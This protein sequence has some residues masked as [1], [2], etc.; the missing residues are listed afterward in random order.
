V[1][2]LDELSKKEKKNWVW[3]GTSFIYP[4]EDL[5]LL[6]L[7]DG[8]KDADE[9]REFDV[10]TKDFVKGGFF[11]PE[12]KNSVAWRNRDE[13]WVAADFGPG[14]MTKSG[15]PR[16][17][18]A[19]KRGTPLSAAKTIYEGEEGDV[20][21][22]AYTV[23]DH[24]KQYEYIYRGTSFFTNESRL[25]VGGNFVLIDK[26]KDATFGSFDDW[27]MLTLRTDWKVGDK[28]YKAGSLI[29]NKLDDYLKGDRNFDVLF[30]PSERTSLSSSTQTENYMILT[31]LDNVCSRPM[32]LEVKNGKWVQNPLPL[33][34]EFAQV[35]YWA[36]DPHHSDDYFFTSNQFLKPNTLYMGT[37]GKSA[38]Q[39]L[40][41]SPSYFNADGLEVQQFQATSKDGTLVPYFQ[42]SKKDLKLYGTNPTLLYGYGGFEVE[43]LPYY[44]ASVGAAWLEKGGVYVLS[45]IRGGGEFGPRWHE[46]ARKENRQRAYDDF[47]AVAED[48]IARK[49][50]S[51]KHLGIQ[52]GSNGGLLMGVMLTQRPELFGAIA[53][54]SPLLDMQRYHKLLAG[55]SWMD[56]YGDPDKADEWAYISKYSP[57][58]NISKDKTYPPILITTSTKDDRVHPGHARKMAAKLK[59]SG[60]EV[61][62]YENIE[63]GH[64]AAADNKEAAFMSALDYDFLWHKLQ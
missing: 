1:L 56:E 43:M 44:G 32:L 31:V 57:Y 20:S 47:A 24:D 48:L 23:H 34:D 42:V 16:I 49:V 11:L 52:G 4:G 5:C 2:D 51:P 59:A 21:V 15:Y 8:G 30:E 36:V 53:C 62:Y 28:T 26:P 38:M 25:N 14:S 50:T 9:V 12:C 61:L 45:N 54:G 37:A 27:A 33:P 63:G 19:W 60:H 46:A 22:S 3:H 39:A 6:S 40:K 10:K 13:L 64:S 41:S 29:C 7:S 35:S 55:A 17:V 58:Q 18:K